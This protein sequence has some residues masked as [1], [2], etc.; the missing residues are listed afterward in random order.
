[1]SKWFSWRNI[2]AIAAAPFTGGTSLAAMNNSKGQSIWGDITGANDAADANE[3][4]VAMQ[5]ETNAL[6]IKL[7][8]SA[9]QRQVADLKAAGLNPV[10][11]AYGNGATTPALESPTVQN[12]MPGGLGSKLATIGGAVA[13][14]NAAMASAALMN[15][16]TATE[17]EK[18]PGV[19]PQQS[20]MINKTNAE[21][22]KAIGETQK[23]EAEKELTKEKIKQTIV[24]T[25]KTITDQEAQIIENI[26]NE[27]NM[28]GKNDSWI[29]SSIK[30]A[31]SMNINPEQI[32]LLKSRIKQE[33]KRTYEQH[34]NK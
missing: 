27:A 1:M 12:T 30:G 17:M 33:R 24:E 9:H 34:Q 13:S 25:G 29:I 20:A 6:N 32:S 19:K 22:A 4:N 16:Q 5:R 31:I 15:A 3:R 2:G 8:N 21:T 11:S 7:A 23:I 14:G 10:L 28:Y 26:I 18:L